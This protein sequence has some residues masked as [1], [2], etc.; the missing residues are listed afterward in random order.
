MQSRILT[1]VQWIVSAVLTL[2]GLALLWGSPVHAQIKPFTPT[3]FTVV[4][5]GTA[6]ADRQLRDQFAVLIQHAFHI[7]Q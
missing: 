6:L 1:W 5:E 7:G 3:R 2:A 4:D